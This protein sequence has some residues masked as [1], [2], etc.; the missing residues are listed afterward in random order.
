[1]H[2]SHSS[3]LWWRFGMLAAAVGI[4]V[5][6]VLGHAQRRSEERSDVDEQVKNWE[7]EGGAAP[8]TATAEPTQAPG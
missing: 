8:S 4:A 1:M 7:N 6:D 3:N 5:M 2:R